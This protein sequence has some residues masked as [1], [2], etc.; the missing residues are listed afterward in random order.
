MHFQSILPE[1]LVSVRRQHLSYGK[2]PDF[3]VDEGFKAQRA[4]V[5]EVGIVVETIA[6]DVGELILDFDQFVNDLALSEDLFDIH[7]FA[8]CISQ[9]NLLQKLFALVGD[10]R[11][12]LL[13]DGLQAIGLLH[14]KRV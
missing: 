8:F 5:L 1:Y 2:L 6:N 3:K 9:L 10:E 11:P 14:V 4:L 7:G 13:P 12:H